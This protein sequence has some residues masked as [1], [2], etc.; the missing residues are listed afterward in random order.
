MGAWGPGDNSRLH[1]LPM[2]ENEQA[3]VHTGPR[4][5]VGAAKETLREIWESMAS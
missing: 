4:I 5:L 3:R 1:C 2:P